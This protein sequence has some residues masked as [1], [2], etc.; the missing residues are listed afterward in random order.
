MA[1]AY[2]HQHLR[3]PAIPFGG[4]YALGVCQDAVAA[5]EKKMTGGAT[6]FPNTADAAL[7]DDPATPKSTSS[8]PLYLAQKEYFTNQYGGR[9][10]NPKTSAAPV[11]SPAA[12]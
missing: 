6:L 8:S 5:I 7:F 11:P 3:R 2:I 1:L 12:Q 9:V 10:L 4:Y